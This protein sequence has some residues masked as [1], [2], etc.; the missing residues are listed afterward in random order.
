MMTN[1]ARVAVMACASYDLELLTQRIYDGVALLG[2]FETWVRPGMNVLL[3]VNLI[4]PMPPEAAATTH[5][6]LVR[7]VIRLLKPLGCTMWVGDSS[8]GAIGGKAQTGRSFAVSGLEQA[9]LEEGAVIK[10][11]DREGIVTVTTTFG[12]TM[13]LAKPVFDADFIINM[14]K[15]KTHLA[16]LYTGAL[17]N[18]YGCIP[19]L[20]KAAYHKQAQSARE[21]GEIICEINRHIRPGLHILDGVM[22]MDR[23]G[24]TSGTVYPAGKLLL[25]TD[26]LALDSVAV[27]MIGR[28]IRK[29]PMYA[30]CVSEKPASAE[31]S[32]VYVCGDFSVPPALPG[33]K[34]PRVLVREEGKNSALMAKLFDMLHTRPMVDTK[35]CRRCNVCVESCPVQ[36]I[37]ARTKRIDYRQCIECMCCHEMCAFRAVRLVRTN[38][39]LR[40]LTPPK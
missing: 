2:G 19:G 23:Q 21:F 29:L 4:G 14:P 9:V 28:D 15:L 5:P 13:H 16:A 17:K 11:F 30:A 35:A 10:N 38:P 26:A 32:R 22:A 25:S 6:A 34:L 3:K 24:P 8:G 40:L 31:P 12:E 37:D 36:A 20:K 7:A 27:R 39:L 1:K 18:L 33:F